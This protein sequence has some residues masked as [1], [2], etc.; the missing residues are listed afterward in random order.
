MRLPFLFSQYFHVQSSQLLELSR[1]N[2]EIGP[3]FSHLGQ[4]APLFAPRLGQI[5]QTTDRETCSF[6]VV[7]I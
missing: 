7:R 5:L 3:L 4:I 1:Q 2:P 6:T